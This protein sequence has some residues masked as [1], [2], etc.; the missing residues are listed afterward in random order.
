MGSLIFR[1]VHH[2]Y[3]KWWHTS[4]KKDKLTSKY[5]KQRGDETW[6]HQD[7]VFWDV[8]PRGLLVY[9]HF[10]G[11]CCLHHQGDDDG[12]P[13]DRGSK[14]LWNAGTL[15]PDYMVQHPRR[16]SPS[17]LPPWEPEISPGFISSSVRTKFKVKAICSKI[18]LYYGRRRANFHLLCETRYVSD[19]SKVGYTQEM[20]RKEKKLFCFMIMPTH[21][22]PKN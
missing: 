20:L 14:H 8:A 19:Q 5:E 15:V 18:T 2:R 3:H 1:L 10:K 13:D 21:N 22:L 16:Q 9:W 11:A 6:I 17:H 4:T 7:N 12:C